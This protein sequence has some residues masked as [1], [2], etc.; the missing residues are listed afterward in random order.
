MHVFDDDTVVCV[1][2]GLNR[3]SKKYEKCLKFSV[4]NLNE[5]FDLEALKSK[6]KPFYNTSEKKRGD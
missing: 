2:F 4:F 5:S 1:A 3:E 6:S